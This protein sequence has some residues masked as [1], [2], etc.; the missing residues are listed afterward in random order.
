MHCPPPAPSPARR[1]SP[2]TC[3][4]PDNDPPSALV[5]RTPDGQLATAFVIGSNLYRSDTFH[6]DAVHYIESD[7]SF[8]IADRNPNVVVK[9]SAT[10][11][12]QWQVG[13]VCD[14]A[15]A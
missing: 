1:A 6:A 2:S 14:N 3:R 8:T 12:P 4:S 5:I 15:P 13:G 11:Q 10:G 7:D 9:V